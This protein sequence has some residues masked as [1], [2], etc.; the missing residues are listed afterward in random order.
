M[1]KIPATIQCRGVYNPIHPAGMAWVG[2]MVTILLKIVPPKQLPA[3]I[4]DALACRED[5][6]HT[7]AIATVVRVSRQP[8]QA[9]FYFD[10]FYYLCREL[11]TPLL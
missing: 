10:I 4:P 5:G 7:T 11:Y 3:A 2:Y 9:N 8:A 6:W 1:M